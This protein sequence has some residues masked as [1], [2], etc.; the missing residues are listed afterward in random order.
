[1]KK[2]SPTITLD[3]RAEN[4]TRIPLS[5][6]RS[7][8]VRTLPFDIKQAILPRSIDVYFAVKYRR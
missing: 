2:V 4:S 7:G 8:N 1:M 6:S 3:W 5:S